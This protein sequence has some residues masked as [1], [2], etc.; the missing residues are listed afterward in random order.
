MIKAKL[1]LLFHKL[2]GF[3][4][5][6]YY[7]SIFKI[8]TLRFDRNENDI[9]LFIE[10]LKQLNKKGI[11]LDIGANIGIMTGV[12]TRL[13][14]YDLHAFEPLPV[15]YSVLN[16]IVSKLRVKD[17]VTLHNIALGN[18]EGFCKMILPIVDQVRMHGLSH[19]IDPSLTDFNE[20]AITNDIP[21]KKLDNL[22]PNIQVSGIKLDVENFEYNVLRGAHAILETQKPII[23]TELWDNDNRK[24]C[25][26]YLRGL[27]YKS[28]YNNKGKL[29]FFE[30]NKTSVQTF[31][32][33]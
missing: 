9:F 1:K 25:F 30:N 29:E 31:F 12:I 27:G 5:F 16:K 21:I 26:E 20:G 33:I 17:R 24:N 13:T 32:F 4:R 23:Y 3:E 28:Y 10:T 6:L 19:V 11:A 22:L 15:N 18:E 7:F 2:L 14:D 8:Y